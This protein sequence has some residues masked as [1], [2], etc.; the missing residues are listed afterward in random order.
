M[1]QISKGPDCIAFYLESNV[2]H[3]KDVCQ[4]V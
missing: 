1:K 4:K 3:A 2:K